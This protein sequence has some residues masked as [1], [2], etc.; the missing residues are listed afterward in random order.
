MDRRFKHRPR[1]RS[2]TTDMAALRIWQHGGA[3]KIE[4][5]ESWN[6]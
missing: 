5:R 3:Y 1:D 6:P 4:R 2:L